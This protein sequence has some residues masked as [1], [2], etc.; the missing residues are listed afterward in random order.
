MNS[1][2]L[3]IGSQLIRPNH[4][5]SRGTGFFMSLTTIA[6]AGANWGLHSNGTIIERFP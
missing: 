3:E 2:K 4:G 1:G 5:L 6:I